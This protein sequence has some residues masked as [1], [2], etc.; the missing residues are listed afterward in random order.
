[1]QWIGGIDGIDRGGDFD[2]MILLYEK[3]VVYHVVNCVRR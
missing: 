1:M 3:R 2:F